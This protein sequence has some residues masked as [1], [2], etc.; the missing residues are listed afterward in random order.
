MI[1]LLRDLSGWVVG[2]AGSD[3][4]ILALAVTSFAESIFFP[5]PPDPLLI[6]IAILHPN[7]AIWLA[8][9]TTISSVAGALVGH[10]LGLRLGRPVLQRLAPENKVAAVERMFEKYGVWA[11][12]VAAITPLP[13]KVFAI[14]AGALRL[15]R[16]TFVL[17][18]LVGRGVRFIPMGV[19]LFFLGESVEGFIADNFDLLTIAFA[20]AVIGAAVAW[21]LLRWRRAGGVVR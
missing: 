2:F 19:L 9:L 8:V 15:D 14:T 7:L 4:A 20:A 12:L 3:W 5:I 10:W 16:R 18:S 13:Y 11:T 6:G 21:W 1:D 17:A